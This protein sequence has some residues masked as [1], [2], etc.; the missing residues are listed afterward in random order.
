MDNEQFLDLLKRIRE[1][2]DIDQIGELFLSVIN[3]YGLTVD[4]VCS[5]SY[6]LVDTTLKAKHNEQFLRD[7]FNIDINTL[8]IDGE[9]AV[10]KAMIATYYDKVSNH[11]RS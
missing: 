6:Y 2:K 1:E 4:E 3:M 11:G 9:L 5:I 7:N 8:G 10:M